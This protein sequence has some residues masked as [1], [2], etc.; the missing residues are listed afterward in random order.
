MRTLTIALALSSMLTVEQRD[1]RRAHLDPPSAAVSAD[2]RY[3]AFTTFS[4]LAPADRDDCRD[5][6]VLDRQ[7]N[8]VTLES[9]RLAGYGSSD[10]SHPGISGDGRF[11]IYETAS[12]IVL[13][14]R[15]GDSTRI[16]GEGR[17]PAI[18]KDGRVAAFTSDTRKD[19]FVWTVDRV[20]N[21]A[22]LS[23]GLSSGTSPVRVGSPVSPSLSDDGRY[24]AFSAAG[25]LYVHDRQART[26][27]HLGDGWDPALSADG[28]Y[29]AYV[30]KVGRVANVLV[31]DRASK[32]SQVI[33]R[34]WKNRASNGASVN[35]VISADGRWVA[36]QSEASN[37]IED[38]DFNLLWD[39]FVFDRER[40]LT[41]RISG[42]LDGGWMEPSSGPAV[43]ANGAT[44][45]FS[46]R[47][48]TDV[49]DKKN[50]FDLFVANMR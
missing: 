25:S 41:A 46:S 15:R 5:V 23:S 37:L 11:L 19:I 8:R 48:P 43:D 32:T 6:Y 42:D 18:S 29:I 44:V 34:S 22:G 21:L 3:V 26:T 16:L 17:Q 2:G 13:K 10:S 14:D 7:G 39:V 4:Q 35:P 31:M 20:S 50:D 1:P 40:G 33:S 45:A 27:E 12:Q 30:A 36:Y 47:H 24:I 38:E 49:S 28:R 9:T